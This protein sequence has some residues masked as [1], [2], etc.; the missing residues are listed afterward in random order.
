[1]TSKAEYQKQVMQ[2]MEL[3]RHG[4]PAKDAFNQAFPNGIPQAEDEAAKAANDQQ[5]AAMG[6]IAGMVGGAVGA[7]ALYDAVTGQPILGGI[8]SKIGG[9][10]GG[11]GTA[12]TTAATTAA[13]AAAAPAVAAVPTVAAPELLAVNAIPGAT[14]AA[15]ATGA[16]GAASGAGMANAPLFGSGL[17]SA[18]AVLATI[19]IAK[20]LQP[21]IYNVGGKLGRALFG[22]KSK[23]HRQFV[24]EEVAA[25]NDFDKQ[26]PGFS[27]LTPEQKFDFVNKAHAAKIGII[28]PG[29]AEMQDGKLVTGEGSKKLPAEFFDVEQAFREHSGAMGFGDHDAQRV[30]TTGLLS[31]A[32]NF[33]YTLADALN[34]GAVR[35]STQDNLRKIQELYGSFQQPQRPE[36]PKQKGRLGTNF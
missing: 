18:G 13:P 34:D 11:G 25:V 27:S 35:R 9:L 6:Q 23:P 2:Y 17:A 16:A 29:F 3:I 21:H 7:K 1:M 19:P 4:V 12:A 20:A 28:T 22:G 30:G 36:Q 15:G 24:A 10:F 33:G 8:G 31:S 14:T 26:L 5:K 32:N